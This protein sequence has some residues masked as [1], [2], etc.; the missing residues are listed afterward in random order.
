MRSAF[1]AVLALMALALVGCNGEAA[2][3]NSPAH[4]VDLQQQAD[5]TFK[6]MTATDPSL[7]NIINSSYAYAVFPEVGEG[8][9]GVGGASGQGIVY[10]NGQAIGTVKLTQVSVGPQIGGQTYSELVVFQNEPAYEKLVNGNL[11]MGAQAT[12]TALKAG[13]AS[14]SRFDQGVAVFVLPKGGLDVGANINGQKFTF[15]P[16]GNASNQ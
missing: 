10:R 9:V 3:P 1:V 11:E 12:A 2:G 14:A 8:A 5:A 13:A 15:T 6:Q 4:T 16:N 7:Q